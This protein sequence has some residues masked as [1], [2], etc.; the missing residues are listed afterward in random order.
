MGHIDLYAPVAHIWYLKSVPSRI[1]LLLDLPVK[2]LE[3]VVYFASYIITDVYEDKK[4]EA[5][6]DVEDRFKVAKSEMQKELQREVNE[7]KLKKESGELTA[8]KFAA[9]EAEVM[10]RLDELVEEFEELRNGLK[11]LKVGEVVG[12]LEYRVLESKFPHVFKGGTGAEYLKTLLARIDLLE[13]IEQQ[14]L[15]LKTATQVKQKKIMQKI[16]LASNLLK[17]G[18]RPEWF[19]LEALPI[20]PP[21]L[22]PMI[23]LDG[24]RFASAD[25]NDLYRR[26]INRNNR[27]KKLIE[28]GAPDVILKNEKRMLQESVDMLVTGE[29]RTNRS[30][31]VT[32]NKKK[33][34]S[35]TEILKGKQGRFRQNL[36]G[37]RVDYSARSVIVVGPNLKIDECGIPKK[38][39]LI[40]FK[41]F[42]IAKL[43]ENGYVYNIKHAEKYIEKGSKEVWD[44]L[45]EVIEGKYVLMN[46]APTL[47]RLSIQAFKPVLIEGKAI[48]LH[49]LTCTAFNA[50]FDG[51][52]MAVHLPITDK[53]QAEAKEL[54]V[55][56]KN[57]LAPASGEP[58]VTPSQ[59][60]I[61]G[62][63]Y[64][65]ALDETGKGAG[66]I[67][68][69]LNDVA[70]AY[71]AG[72]LGMKSP[73]K[74]RING[75]IIDTCY[76]RLLFNEI[77]PK[78][79]GFI[80]ETL[81][82]GV[83]KRILAQSFEELGGETTAQFVDAIKNFG[84]RYSTISGLSISKNDMVVPESK[85]ELLDAAG[86]KVKY[87]QKKHWTG[88]LTEEE[89]YLQSI[90][91]WA[92]VKKVIESDMKQLFDGKNHIYNFIDSGSRGN[93]G[94]ITQLCGMKGLVASTSGATI[95]LPIKSTLKEGFSSLEYFI[96]THG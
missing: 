50:D 60:M 22:R 83:L 38:M 67:F 86:E 20:I 84:Y 27:L 12:E 36:L 10:A 77:V 91:I 30:G 8:K 70:N 94:N 87:I 54:M 25:L 26:V 19:I 95:E 53:A 21:D 32:A 37:K 72:V 88:F 28:L 69:D 15:E 56:S 66:K 49:P 2:K 68:K 85:Q 9:A 33:L 42:V 41:P 6:R 93:W 24:G 17:S 76:G 81:K 90:A 7:L 92:E 1:G 80:N 39:A 43:I 62:C 73:I 29:T 44:S 40:L 51:D 74:V 89:K 63:Y 31:F 16:K 52:Q 18:Q 55:T 78:E 13:F 35:L 64:V 3:Q 45:D 96:A 47:H 14:E 59:D 4:E 82:K 48:Q 57:L 11:N 75:E 34:K 46:R 79:L 61:L 23:Q 71:D 58:I 65:T 5:L